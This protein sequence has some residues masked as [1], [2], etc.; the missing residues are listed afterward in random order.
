M[1]RTSDCEKGHT[2]YHNGNRL[3]KC[4]GRLT[5]LDQVSTL[6]SISVSVAAIKRIGELVITLQ[7]IDD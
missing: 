7:G 1:G 4:C 3:V 6:K 2:D 5:G